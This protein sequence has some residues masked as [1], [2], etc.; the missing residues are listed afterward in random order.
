[1]AVLRVV[2]MLLVAVVGVV[3]AARAGGRRWLPFLLAGAAGWIVAQ[4][5]KTV[6]ALP[7]LMSHGASAAP[8][9]ATAAWYPFFAALLPG[10]FEELA[11]WVPLRSMRVSD[12]GQA[13]ALGL[14]VGAIE[15]LSV[16]L[17]LLFLP[18]ASSA[19]AAAVGVAVWERIWAVTLHAGLAT[20]DGAAVALGRGRWLL[21][22]MALHF[23][24]NLPA[25]EYQRLSLLGSPSARTVLIATEILVV[26]FALAAL[27][28]GRRLWRSAGEAAS[29]GQ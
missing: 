25:G 10:V 12:R 9:I 17:P 5:V 11:K 23:L 4:V 6:F 19:T 18:G 26:A 27:W 3:V 1:M 24:A 29:P 22:A 8:L 16:A 21:A 2:L 7:I 14:G 20:I 28:I 13:L 15:V